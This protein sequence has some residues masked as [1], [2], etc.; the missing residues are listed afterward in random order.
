MSSWTDHSALDAAGSAVTQAS[1]LA[2]L[3]DGRVEIELADDAMPH[4][5]CEMLQTQDGPPLALKRHDRVLIW[6]SSTTPSHAII[7]G[8][9]GSSEPRKARKASPPRAIPEPENV[10]REVG[11]P[12]E[13]VLEAKHSMTLRVGEGSITIREDGKILIKGKDLVSHAQRMNRIKGG[14]VSIN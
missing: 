10:P 2:V 13:L 3:D 6:R 11:T 9:L 4:L 1:V 7:L 14:A 12:D 8:R 5:I